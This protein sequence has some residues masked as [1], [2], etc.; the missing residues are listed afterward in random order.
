M[1]WAEGGMT[2]S[3]PGETFLSGAPGIKPSGSGRERRAV[4]GYRSGEEVSW[5]K[6]IASLV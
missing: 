3:R 6:L 2:L 5:S 4:D 1:G